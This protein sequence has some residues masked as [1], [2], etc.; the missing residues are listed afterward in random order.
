MLSDEDKKVLVEKTKQILEVRHI[1]LDVN[2]IN[3][4]DILSLI[5]DISEVIKSSINI[6]NYIQNTKMDERPLVVIQ[7][8]L[9]VISDPELDSVLSKDIKIKIN[10]FVNSTETANTLISAFSWVNT[11]LLELLDTNND[12][13]VSA[14]EVEVACYNCLTCTRGEKTCACYESSG[15]CTCCSSFSNKLSKIFSEIFMRVIC[16]GCSENQISYNSNDT[17]EKQVNIDL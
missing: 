16:C 17:E 5:G 10:D 6:T 13:K 14:L 15:C 9:E 1:T 8:I 4:N 11:E 3:P 7:I 2:D 12:G